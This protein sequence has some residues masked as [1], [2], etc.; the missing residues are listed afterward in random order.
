MARSIMQIK[1][2]CFICRKAAAAAGYEGELQDKGLHRHHVIFGRGYRSLSEKFG[3]WI[4]L[5]PEHHRKVHNDKKL[6][7][8]LRQQAQRA[9]LKDHTIQEWM[10]IFTRNYLDQNEINRIMTK[11]ENGQKTTNAENT[12]ITDETTA[13]NRMVTKEPPPGF[14]FIE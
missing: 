14:W 4:Y 8:E 6:N 2:E 11:Q 9:F 13:K 12:Q 7:V 10:D 3:L 5:C 1:K